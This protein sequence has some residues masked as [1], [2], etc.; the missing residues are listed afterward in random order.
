MLYNTDTNYYHIIRVFVNNPPMSST[1]HNNGVKKNFL[2]R[3]SVILEMQ[4]TSSCSRSDLLVYIRRCQSWIFTM[5]LGK[6]RINNW[7][8][9][10]PGRIDNPRPLTYSCLKMVSDCYYIIYCD[11]PSENKIKKENLFSHPNV[12]IYSVS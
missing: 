1:I 5:C 7:S 6:T 9:S 8:W 3:N 11:E 12:N 10:I 2:Q 4:T